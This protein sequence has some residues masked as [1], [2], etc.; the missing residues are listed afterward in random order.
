MN[1][2]RLATV[3]F[4]L[5]LFYALLA[6]C[7]RRRQRQPTHHKSEDDL[8]FDNDLLKYGREGLYVL[9]C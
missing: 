5:I 3:V 9:S 7:G 4:P 6:E 2:F 8:Q 1:R